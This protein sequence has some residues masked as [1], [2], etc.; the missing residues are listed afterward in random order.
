MIRKHIHKVKRKTYRNHEK[1]YFCILDCDYKIN[2]AL[3]EGKE[4]LCHRCGEAFK[5]NSYSIRLAKP[6]CPK[7]QN[8]KCE[9]VILDTPDLDISK[10]LDLKPTITTEARSNTESKSKT[11]KPIHDDTTED[12]KAR[13]SKS[14]SSLISSAN[15]SNDSTEDD[16]L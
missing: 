5:M 9:V 13:L 1:V 12:L 4:F 15:D 14:I 10:L 7:C 3:A 8:E 11:K 6:H 2:V 16:L